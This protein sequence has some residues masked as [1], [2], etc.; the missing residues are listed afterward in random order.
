MACISGTG[1]LRI[2]FKARH[3]RSEL[4]LLQWKR[5][6]MTQNASKKTKRQSKKRRIILENGDQQG[7]KGLNTEEVSS[8][9]ESL[10]TKQ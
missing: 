5:T 8:A 1:T 4:M 6:M 2:L 10:A 3:V 9:T 7:Q